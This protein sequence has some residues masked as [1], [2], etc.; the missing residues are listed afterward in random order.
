MAPTPK[1]NHYLVINSVPFGIMACFIDPEDV[2]G[3]LG[4]DPPLIGDNVHI[5]GEAGTVD[6]DKDQDELH[7]TFPI[8]LNGRYNF[9]DD[10]WNADPY[11]GLVAN[12]DHLRSSIGT[13][14]TVVTCVEHKPGG[15]TV[16]TSV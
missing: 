1:F 3:P 10:T 16:S 4:E 13:R 2:W 15:S 12:R 7:V 5:P 6:Y 11:A 9:T 8:N 14:G